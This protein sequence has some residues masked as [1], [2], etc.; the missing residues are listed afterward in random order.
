M[1]IIFHRVIISVSYRRR[2]SAPHVQIKII[3][4]KDVFRIGSL[5]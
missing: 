1:V 2:G 4:K 3:D 5:L